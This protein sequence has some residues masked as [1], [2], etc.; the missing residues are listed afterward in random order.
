MSLA[1]FIRAE[2]RDALP[3]A[4]EFRAAGFAVSTALCTGK[5][6]DGAKRADDAGPLRVASPPD[7]AGPPRLPVPERQRP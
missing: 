4:D 6:T 5:K 7:R 1:M 2:R 3:T